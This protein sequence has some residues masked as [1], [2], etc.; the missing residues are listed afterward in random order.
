MET[1]FVRLPHDRFAL[2]GGHH[3]EHS[4]HSLRQ[5]SEAGIGCLPFNLRHS[6]VD[7]IN[8]LAAALQ[9]AE[10]DVAELASVV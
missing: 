6:S 8:S 9:L 2:L 7:G 3:N 5:G 4:V 10:R 1:G